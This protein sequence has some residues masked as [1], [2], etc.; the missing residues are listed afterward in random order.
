VKLA[1]VGAGYVGIVTA[2]CLAEKGHDVTCVDI[3]AD[4]VTA[5][6]DGR[7]PVYEEGLP[8]LLARNV[9]KRLVATTDVG[10]AGE[11][12]ISMIAVGTPF[13]GG[14]ADLTAIRAAARDIGGALRGRTGYHVVCVKS[15]VLPGTTD[16]V[17][18]PIVEE[19]SGRRLGDDIGLAM[20][21]EFLTE[22]QSV[23]DFMRPDRL[24]LGGIDD[25]SI[26]CLD[27]LY[28]RFEGV[29]RLRVGTRTAEMI[30]Y[31]SNA[32]LATSISFANQI[33]DLC[34]ADGA[35]D[36]VDVMQGVHMSRYLSPPGPGGEPTPAPIASFLEAG[37]G[38]GGSCLPKDVR[39]LVAHAEAGGG[40]APLLRAVLE[41]NDGR[42]DVLVAHVARHVQRVEGVRVAVL[43][44]AFKPGTDDTRES[45]AVPVIDRLQGLGARVVVHDPVAGAAAAERYGDRVEIAESLESAVQEADVVVI[46]T[47]WPEYEQLPSIL[48]P[49][50]SRAPVV[51]DGRRMLHRGAVVAYDGIG[52]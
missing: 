37:C 20:N 42:A 47:R 49:L 11:C 52:L 30:K 39:S 8:E 19:A 28:A 10:V 43:G 3:D 23:E 35:I 34:S 27:A 14:A 7:A 40:R 36:V 45:P 51:V 33:A 32:L 31:A 41:V 12:D 44:F 26:E 24:V 38:F 5:I 17:V 6:N 22:G 1:V 9:G 48:A 16:Q 46:V 29:P 15:T 50:G 21:P 2:A 18:G 4:R 13:E 25:R